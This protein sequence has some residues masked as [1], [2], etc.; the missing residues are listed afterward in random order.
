VR[1]R[2]QVAARQI[3]YREFG[4]RGGTPAI[5]LH[6][7]PSSASEGRWLDAPACA[8]GVRIVAL[9]RR[10]YLGSDAHAPASPLGVAGDVVA[11]ADALELERFAVVGF[12][13]GAGY[14]LAT[15]YAAPERVTVVHVG[16]GLVSLAGAA[17][18][19]MPWQR[20]LPF[21][22][23]TRAPVV[24]RP[25][26]AGGMRLFRRA[27]EKRLDSSVE[28]AEWF[29]DGPARGDQVEAVADYIRAT[30]PDDL[31]AD[32]R[33]HA[34]ATASTQAILGDVASYTRPCPF[35][36]GRVDVPVELWHGTDDPAVPVA[37]AERA[38]AEL[39]RATL[40]TF[41][42][43]GHF[44]FHSHGAEIVESIALHVAE[45]ARC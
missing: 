8:A 25:L 4:D 9:D 45:V 6:G 37:F 11:V 40:H 30:P 26:V 13:G 34:R 43:E 18:E 5:Y 31:E 22:L 21:V 38:A 14:A 17:G 29:F 1:E 32:L 20:R 3:E 39:P 2:V 35:E 24:A 27:I 36:L 33:D 41:P 28:A 12:S 44:V 23:M 42:G 10:G 19:A 7:T 15:A 16:G